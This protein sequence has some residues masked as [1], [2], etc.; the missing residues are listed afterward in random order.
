MT[1]IGLMVVVATLLCGACGSSSGSDSASPPTSSTPTP[2]ISTSPLPASP[3]PPSGGPTNV[4]VNDGLTA[5]DQKRVN[6]A[7]AEMQVAAVGLASHG[8]GPKIHAKINRLLRSAGTLFEEVH[9][10]YH[11]V[12]ART[13]AAGVA[14]GAK[15]LGVVKKAVSKCRSLYGYRP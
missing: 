10:P 12:F 14:F 9:D 7:C 1:R 2:T 13:A 5:A 3:V 4:P 11:H 15:A 6:A 8:G